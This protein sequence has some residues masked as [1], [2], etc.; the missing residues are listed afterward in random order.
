LK[1]GAF[2]SDLPRLSSCGAISRKTISP[3]TSKETQQQK[4]LLQATFKQKT[5]DR[6]FSLR[7]FSKKLYFFLPFDIIKTGNKKI[8]YFKTTCAA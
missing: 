6:P 4:A 2:L 7:F 1:N 5:P 3:E 8:Y